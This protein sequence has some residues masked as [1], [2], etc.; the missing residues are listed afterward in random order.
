MNS[1]FFPHSGKCTPSFSIAVRAKLSQNH[2]VATC[3]MPCS[4]PENNAFR[5]FNL[6]GLG[7][8]APVKSSLRIRRVLFREYKHWGW[9]QG[10]ATNP[11]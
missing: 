5:L 2:Q 4:G 10:S 9:S 7:V 8:V 1:L 6:L 3:A 11:R